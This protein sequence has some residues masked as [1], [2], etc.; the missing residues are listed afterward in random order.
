MKKEILDYI[1]NKLGLKIPKKFEFEEIK[2]KD[3]NCYHVG[4]VRFK[5]KKVY[6][7]TALSLK[8][9]DVIPSIIS[10]N[11]SVGEFELLDWLKSYKKMNEKVVG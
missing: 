8:R 11:G 9:N 4:V 2:E 6:Y 7:I 3:S 1:K 5:L 10:I